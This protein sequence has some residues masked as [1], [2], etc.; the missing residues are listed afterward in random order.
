M[1]DATESS[2]LA[3]ARENWKSTETALKTLHSGCRQAASMQLS[4]SYFKVNGDPI[5][6][7]LS[8]CWQRPHAITTFANLSRLH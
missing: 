3:T 5:Q 4:V 8:V 2:N 6:S 1:E 7:R